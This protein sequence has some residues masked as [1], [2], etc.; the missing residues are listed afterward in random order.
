MRLTIYAFIYAS[1]SDKLLTRFDNKLDI[2]LKLS[3]NFILHV[4]VL[5]LSICF[6]VGTEKVLY[7]SVFFPKHTMNS[8]IFQY[9]DNDF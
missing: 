2:N 3:I 1:H 4:V 7:F 8:Y 6:L 5:P 9:N